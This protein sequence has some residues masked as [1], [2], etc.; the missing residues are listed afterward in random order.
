M[1]LFYRQAD[2]GP[3][4]NSQLSWVTEAVSHKARIWSSRIPKHGF[5]AVKLQLALTL[6]FGME[7]GDELLRDVKE[8]E[9]RKFPSYRII[10]FCLPQILQTFFCVCV[11]RGVVDNFCLDIHFSTWLCF[12][13]W[14]VALDPD[15]ANPNTG[16]YYVARRLD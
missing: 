12:C 6:I 9:S 3:R 13:L 14:G 10:L 4:R 7:K 2:R 8:T 15:L 1:L 11:W 16:D 5:F